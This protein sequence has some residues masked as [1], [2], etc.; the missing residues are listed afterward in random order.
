MQA[1][2]I[3]EIVNTVNGK[4]Y[5]GSAVNFS[6][7][8]TRHK[9]ELKRKEHHSP[10]LQR[11]W[12]K[13]GEAAFK[14]LPIL[15]CQTSMLDFYEQQLLDKVKPEYNIATS[16]TQSMLGRKHSAETK[17]KQAAA[18][19]GK[20]ASAE[21]RIKIGAASRARSAES[22]AK[23]AAAAR[24]RPVSDATCEKLSRLGKGRVLG[25]QSPEHIAKLSLARRGHGH[26]HT[27]ES[28]RRI[29]EANT[30]K[31][32]SEEFCAAN[33]KAQRGKILPPETRAKISKSLL[34]NTHTKGRKLSPE[35][36]AA[37]RAGHAAYYAGKGGQA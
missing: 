14:F 1:G 34:G 26:A 23:I 29:S 15:T 11:A 5:I 21:T 36:V 2:G 24:G 19:M 22:N 9:Y 32:R 20:I 8:F 13:H 25:P 30:G 17:A 35:H 10:K 12:D 3:Y 33:A 31:K 7:R 27:D 6:K 16:V 4:R 18:K 37:M 28:K